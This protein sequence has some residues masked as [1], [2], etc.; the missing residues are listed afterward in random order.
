MPA[1]LHVGPLADDELAALK[2]LERTTR[3]AAVR[4]RCLMVLRAHGGLTPRAI[5]CL[6]G[7]DPSTVRRAIR[8]YERGG[9]GALA[10]GR[11]VRRPRPGSAAPAA[12]AG[13]IEGRVE[14]L[15]HE[16]RSPLSTIL[17][18]AH[19]LE[20]PPTGSLDPARQAEF[21]AAILEAGEH[22]L[23]LLSNLLDL[24]R[25]EAGAAPRR[26]SALEVGSVLDAALRTV[27]PRAAEKAIRTSVEFEP[28]LPAWRGDELLVRRALDNLLSN[29]VKYTPPGGAVRLTA[30]REGDGVAIAVSDTGIGLT[31]QERARIFERFFRGGRPEARRERGT[32]LGLSIAQE[33]ARRLGGVIRVSSRVGRGSTFT[34]RLPCDG[35][36]AA[37]AA[38]GLSAD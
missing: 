9:P 5:G 26:A 31:G 19:L 29:A 6:L 22:M 20:A 24:H 32:G 16:L 33:A 1:R 34:L 12:P 18:Y 13:P 11:S 4:S 10:D 15:E 28:G 38:A 7:R 36:G 35:T 14:D 17:G 8:R 30:G 2:G 21:A 3:D 27:G 25:I 37:R 23:R